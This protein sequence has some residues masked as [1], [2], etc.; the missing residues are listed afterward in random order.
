MIDKTSWIS[1]YPEIILFFMA[2]VIAMVDLEVK[3]AR[4]TFTY[5]LTLAT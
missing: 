5:V 3:S 2:C 1:V 4:R